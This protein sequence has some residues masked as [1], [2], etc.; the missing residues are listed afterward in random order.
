MDYDAVSGL[1]VIYYW[2]S[3][4]ILVLYRA[5]A[6]RGTQEPQ[7]DTLCVRCVHFLAACDSLTIG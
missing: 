2:I 5:P 7:N 6:V 4:F 3:I 1:W